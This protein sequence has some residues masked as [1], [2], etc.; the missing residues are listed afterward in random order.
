MKILSW[1]ARGLGNPTAF[2]HLKLLVRQLSP[3]VLFLMETRLG[4]YSI[5]KFRHSLQ[6]NNGL[7]SPRVGLS[8]GLMLL[9]K[10]N[11]NVSLNVFG[12][13][14]FD[15]FLSI[16]DGPTFH[17]TAFYGAPAASNRS[18][19]WTLL[20]RLNDI[21]PTMPWLVTGD[22][23]EIL[24]QSDKYGG[25]LRNESQIEAFRK[26]LDHYH[27]HDLPYDG[28]RFT[29]V[30][31]RTAISTTKERLDWVFT[32]HLWNSCFDT[33]TVSHLD[34]FSSDHRTV[35]A[36]VAPLNTAASS[37]RQRSRF[38]FEKLW[39]VDPESKDIITACWS[40]GSHSDPISSIIHKLESCATS[41]Q[42]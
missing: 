25:P 3:Q 13:T 35:D 38:R 30:K 14:Y 29:W 26:A 28:D 19:S 24:S 4:S 20:Q 27:L 31:N 18:S 6:F 11:I 22:F 33:P 10:D 36:I 15:S 8:G 40:H 2:R 1:N 17:F 41:L 12:P 21:A 16:D 23:N 9:W 42:Q 32:N 34:F 5:S 7:E 39:L 37:H